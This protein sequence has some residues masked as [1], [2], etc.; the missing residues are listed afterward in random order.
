MRRFPDDNAWNAAKTSIPEKL[1]VHPELFLVAVE[2][3]AT[4]R[5]A[6]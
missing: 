3:G 5:D 1:K 4:A 6:L 2:S